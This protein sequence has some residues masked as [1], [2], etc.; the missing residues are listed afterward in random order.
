MSA[1][2][3]HRT[4]ADVMTTRVHVASPETPFKTLVRLIEEN[5]IS[6]VPIVDHRGIP[7]GV[8][9]ESD[10]LF[11]E[12]R[13]ELET[14]ADL[15]HP[16]RRQRERAKA[17]GL[18]AADVM[19]SPPITVSS[20]SLLVEAARV[21]QR[22][23]VRRLVVVNERGRI[24]GVVSR[25]DLLQVFLRSDEEL[26]GEIVD[27]V[28]PALMLTPEHPIAVDVSDNVVT[29][30]GEVDRKSDV[31]VLGRLTQE[32]DGVIGVVNQ[33]SYRWNDIAGIAGGV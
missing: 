9:S 18:V 3:R 7:I 16:R 23:N 29:L 6:A 31:E 32:L 26:L 33:L 24:S 27:N 2:P 21:M 19:T 1:L 10:L 5:R 25:S 22:R 12:R 20:G 28:I 17:D 11:K 15:L 30:R 4:V 14:K 8:V 13:E